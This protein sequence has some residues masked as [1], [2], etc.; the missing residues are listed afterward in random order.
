MRRVEQEEDKTRVYQRSVAFDNLL[1]RLLD[2]RGRN[3]TIHTRHA[4]Q[5]EDSPQAAS[6]HL[7]NTNEWRMDSPPFHGNL[8]AA[9]LVHRLAEFRC[10]AVA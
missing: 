4:H 8:C 6:R 3:E 5:I 7:Q 2:A 1:G 10:H 9:M